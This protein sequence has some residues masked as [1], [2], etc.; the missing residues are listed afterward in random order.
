MNSKHLLEAVTDV[1]R[2][3]YTPKPNPITKSTGMTL[4]IMAFL[5][6]L[7][8]SAA[9]VKNISLAVDPTMSV[10]GTFDSKGRAAMQLYA[11]SIATLTSV[12]KRNNAGLQI[13]KV[14]NKLLPFYDASSGLTRPDM[15]TILQKIQPPNDNATPEAIGRT[16]YSCAR[17][18]GRRVVEPEGTDVVSAVEFVLSNPNTVPVVL[19]DGNHEGG[20]RTS[21]QLLKALRNLSTQQKAKLW[22][23]G[24]S[25]ENS[26]NIKK[27]IPNTFTLDE[28]TAGITKLKAFLK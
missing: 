22:L 26:L 25:E 4:I 27:I 17:R 10:R 1:L 13:V 2:N 24:I 9:T 28:L 19:T 15:A 8:L 23:L 18:I 3:S 7:V 11:K 6:S 21:E 16:L 20:K 14:C 5:T 12:T